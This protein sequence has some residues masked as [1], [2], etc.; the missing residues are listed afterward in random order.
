MIGTIGSALTVGVRNGA[1]LLSVL[2]L[3]LYIP[4]LIFAMA[5][6]QAGST[7]L[8]AAS[9][10]SLL[11][12][13][14]VLAILLADRTSSRLNFSHQ[15]AARMPSSASQNNHSNTKFTH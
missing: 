8:G 5:A 1:L 15:C 10:L 13:F 4:V 2:E 11:G 7:G 9:E 12:S 3:H 6:V 14:L